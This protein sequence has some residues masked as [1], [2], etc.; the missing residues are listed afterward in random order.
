MSLLFAA[1]MACLVIGGES[2]CTDLCIH[3]ECQAPMTS[4]II[5]SGGASACIW[6]TVCTSSAVMGGPFVTHVICTCPAY[7][8]LLG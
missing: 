3:P 4:Y 2:E 7:G 6:G 1:I 8:K 5:C